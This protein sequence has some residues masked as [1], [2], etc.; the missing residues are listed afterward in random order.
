M[1]TRNSVVWYAS[2]AGIIMVSVPAQIGFAQQADRVR[3]SHLSSTKGEIPQPDVGRQVATLILD[4][5]RTGVWMSGSTAAR[6]P[7]PAASGPAPAS[8]VPPACSSTVFGT[9]SETTFCGLF[10]GAPMPP[11]SEF[12]RGSEGILHASC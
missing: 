4:I 11:L 8:G 3:W 2:L 9:S 5:D 10:S 7:A 12:T 1:I 6:G